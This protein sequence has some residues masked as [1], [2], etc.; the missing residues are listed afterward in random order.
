LGLP[1]GGQA[2]SEIS[3]GVAGIEKSLRHRA[4]DQAVVEMAQAIV[5]GEPLAERPLARGRWP[6]DGDDHER[7]APRPR[8]KAE[9]PGK[10]VAMM[11][12]SSTRTGCSL[13]KPMTRNAMAMR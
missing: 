8:I 5:G 7:S 13:A 3:R 12:A 2:P 9:K 10:L 6:I 1:G 11:A 4:V